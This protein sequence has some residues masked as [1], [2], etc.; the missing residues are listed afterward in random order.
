[1]VKSAGEITPM[2]RPMFSKTSSINPRVFISTPMELASRQDMPE[3]RAAT[4]DPPNFPTIATLII[5]TVKNQLAAPLTRPMLVRKPL[6]AKNMG[7]KSTMA[8]SFNFSVRACTKAG[9]FGMI[10]PIRKAPNRAWM[11][12]RSVTRPETSTSRRI[13]ARV[14]CETC[15]RCSNLVSS[16]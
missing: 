8:R 11:P 1:M 14:S 13:I 3:M 16:W 2:S 4:V 12:S 6:K 5:K 9:C 15:P 10:T 7:S